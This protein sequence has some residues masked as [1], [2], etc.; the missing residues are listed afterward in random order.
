MGKSQTKSVPTSQAKGLSSV[1]IGLRTAAT[2]TSN[3]IPESR[4][5]GD[6]NA[7]QDALEGLHGTHING[8]AIEEW[9]ENMPAEIVARISFALTD[10]GMAEQAKLSQRMTLPA[11]GK[12]ASD[13]MEKQII[14]R[15]EFRKARIDEGAIEDLELAPD[16]L[17]ATVERFREPG[18]EYGFLGEAATRILGDRRYEVVKDDR[19]NP[20]TVGRLTLGRIPARVKQARQEK[21][22]QESQQRIADVKDEYRQSVEK[23]KRDAK[24]MGLRVVEEG[25]IAGEFH[26]TETGRRVTIG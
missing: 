9:A 5:F 11:D 17:A 1:G 8:V 19:G 24:D 6:P 26:N 4:N 20:V 7:S 16:I 23:L 25:E 15:G 22:E 12:P 14:A 10:E 13:P 3:A 18:F 2:A 21:R